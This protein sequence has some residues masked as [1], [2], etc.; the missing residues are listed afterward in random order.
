MDRIV[1]DASRRVRELKRQQTLVEEDNE[2]EGGVMTCRAPRNRKKGGRDQQHF[3]NNYDC[4]DGFEEQS[5]QI[6]LSSIGEAL[7]WSPKA[8]PK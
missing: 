5:K 3:E 4:E 8:S 2:M 6:D 7:D 1:N